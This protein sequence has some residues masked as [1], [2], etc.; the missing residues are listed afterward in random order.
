MTNQDVCAQL[1][2]LSPEVEVV[3]L[4]GPSGEL[5]GYVGPAE[6]ESLIGP[7]ITPLLTLADRAGQE[8]GRGTL[9]LL[10]TQGSRGQVIAQD[11]GGG[12]ALA[13]IVRPGAALGLLVDDVRAAADQLNR[14]AA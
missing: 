3:A 11:L 5:D 12:R 2:K 10:I 8:L 9:S 14:L 6:V 7:M 1:H 13:L 4:V